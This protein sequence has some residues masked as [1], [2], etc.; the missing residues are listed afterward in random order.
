VGKQY[1]SATVSNL[2]KLTQNI[3]RIKTEAEKPLTNTVKAVK[4]K[5][6][7]YVGLGIREAYN[8]GAAEA[9][10]RLDK[11]ISSAKSRPGTSIKAN[12]A[13]TIGGITLEYTGRV[14]T[15]VV[16][17]GGR[18]RFSVGKQGR[19]IKATIERGK[20]KPIKQSDPLPFQVK[21][22]SG[23]ILPFYRPDGESRK[24][25]IIKK[26]AIPQMIETSK[27]LNELTEEPIRRHMNEGI[28]AVLDKQLAKAEKRMNK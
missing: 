27:G 16:G 15:P 17:S 24:V 18:A 10:G 2:A 22:K 7:H 6:P 23:P 11:K 20:R 28:K 26:I 4:R 5:L 9:E 1:V 21:T 13:K 12:G 25:H 3:K 8:I 19:Y 14:L